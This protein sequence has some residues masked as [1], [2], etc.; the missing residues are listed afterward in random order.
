LK[1]NDF[2]SHLVEIGLILSTLVDEMNKIH[3]AIKN[4]T[5][6]SLCCDGHPTIG[7]GPPGEDHERIGDRDARFHQ[8]RPPLSR[9]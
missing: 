5:D 3:Y 6:P 7:P 4:D 8:Q 1:Y 9:L 2:Q